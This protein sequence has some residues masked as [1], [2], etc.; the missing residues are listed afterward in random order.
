YLPW[1]LRRAAQRA[2]IICESL[3][4]PASLMPPLRAARLGAALV[5]D[6]AAP[7]RS[8]LIRAQRARAAAAIRARPA[9]DIV[10]LRRPVVAAARLVAIPPPPPRA[11]APPAPP[12]SRLESWFRSWSICLRKATAS[13]SCLTDRSMAGVISHARDSASNVLHIAS[14]SLF[15]STD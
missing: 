8:A 13:S 7:P 15:W 6:A 4:R 14:K 9:A 3:R 12:P 1:A 10:P 2:F 11:P 5:L